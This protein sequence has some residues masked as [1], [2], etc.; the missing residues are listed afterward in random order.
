MSN[1][2]TPE[3]ETKDGKK[4]NDELFRLEVST[5][6]VDLDILKI[7]AFTVK[8]GKT[9]REMSTS[10]HIPIGKTYSLVEWMEEN[11]FLEEIGKHRTA[12]HGKATRYISTVKSGRIELSNNKLVIICE[13]KN[14]ETATI[15]ECM[16]E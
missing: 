6:V 11:G 7:V 1:Y 2:I 3:S 13:Q 10:L 14:G 12:L 16:G 15:N 9:V 5:D 8:K 4:E